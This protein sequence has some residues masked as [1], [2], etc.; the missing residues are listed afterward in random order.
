MGTG[1]QSTEQAEPEPGMRG[2]DREGGWG[3]GE[4]RARGGQLLPLP[5]TTSGSQG[6]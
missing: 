2:A 6:T 5:I 4:D 3:R 1:M